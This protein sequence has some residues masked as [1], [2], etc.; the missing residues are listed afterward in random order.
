MRAITISSGCRA[1][2]RKRGGSNYYLPR[3]HR[4]DI[5]HRDSPLVDLGDA[6][7]QRLLEVASGLDR[8]G[9]P[10]AEAA[11]D[12]GEVDFRIEHRGADPGVFERPFALAGDL[13]LMLLVVPERAVVVD[14]GE[15][16]NAVM[17][18]GP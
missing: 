10:C 12:G 13:A 8:A 6:L 5:D 17:H 3:P 11:A 4:A 9:R 14:H 18:G 15:Q 7:A 16:R 2:T 1:N